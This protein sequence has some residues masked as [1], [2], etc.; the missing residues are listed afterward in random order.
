MQSRERVRSKTLEDFASRRFRKC[1]IIRLQDG[2]QKKE[3]ERAEGSGVWTSLDILHNNFGSDVGFSQ[4]TY[5]WVFSVKCCIALRNVMLHY[6][7]SS[8]RRR[9]IGELVYT[10]NRKRTRIYIHVQSVLSRRLAVSSPPK[11]TAR[12]NQRNA[13][14]RIIA[15]RDRVHALFT[16]IG[17]E[18]GTGNLTCHVTPSVMCRVTSC[19]VIERSFSASR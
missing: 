18:G 1:E 19:R 16:Y 2:T 10:R 13:A 17:E 8:S 15:T 3:R 6:V 4:G 5:T 12:R 11:S 9:E 7:T 14:L